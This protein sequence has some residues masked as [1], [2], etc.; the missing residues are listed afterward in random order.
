MQLF[1]QL[2]RQQTTTMENVIRDNI[3]NICGH[4]SF[5]D[6]ISQSIFA[7]IQ[8]SLE[9]IFKKSLEEIMIPSYEKIT[10]EMFQEMGKAFTAGTKECKLTLTLSLMIFELNFKKKII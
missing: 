5:V 10:H 7:G 6:G 1:N 9:Q 3:K 4:K 8:K 2:F